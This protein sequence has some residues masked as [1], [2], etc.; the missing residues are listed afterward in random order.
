MTY[1]P[2]AGLLTPADPLNL[3]VDPTL[4]RTATLN[5]LLPGVCMRGMSG[6]PNT[7]YNL[8]YRMAEAGVP[9]RYIS[10][11]A[12]MDVDLEPIWQHIQSL[13]G[14]ARKLPNVSFADGHNRGRQVRIGADDVFLATAW[15]TAQMVKYALPLVRPQRFLYVIQDFEPVLHEHSTAHALALETY[16]LD[17]VP[18]VNHRFLAE[19]LQQA[20]VGRFADP[21]FAAQA[22][23]IDPALDRTRFFPQLEKRTG[24]RR[25]LFYARPRSASRNLFELGI[26]A[27]QRAVQA[28]AFAAE[29]WEFLAMGDPIAPVELGQGHVLQPAPWRD[30]DGYAAQMRDADVLLSLMLSPHPSYPPLEMA[31]C[32]GLVVTNSFANKTQA[33]FAAISPNIMAP[34]AT[35]EGIGDA[36]AMAAARVADLPARK[37]G[38]DLSSP[39]TWS[40]AFEPVLPRA[41]AAFHACRRTE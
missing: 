12:D 9:V 22:V 34:P 18:F 32:G 5:V 25:L 35:I 14:I 6:G 30:F 2:A 11:S 1:T 13:S 40:D 33:A 8:T 37:A 36:L 39:A 17:Y 27:L 10:T 20:K 15:W 26:A 31:A 38:A 4:S 23:V 19:Y 7:I 21:A 28:G 24:K 29:P 41:V 3:V 16:G